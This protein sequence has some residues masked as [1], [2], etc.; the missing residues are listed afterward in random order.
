MLR[1]AIPVA[2]PT[3]P[4]AGATDLA[5]LHPA[6]RF[7]PA[8]N[9]E[10]SYRRRITFAQTDIDFELGSEVVDQ[11][12]NPV[13]GMTIRPEAFHDVDWLKTPHVCPVLGA[14]EVWERV[15]TTDEMHNFHIHQSKFRLA[16]GKL[17]KAIPAGLAP[18]VATGD[19]CTANPGKVAF[20]DPQGIVGRAVIETGGAMRQDSAV[21]WHD[22]IPVPPRGANGQPGRV[23][24]SIPFKAPE[25]V[26]RLVFHCHILEHEDGGM[27]APV[28]VFGPATIAQQQY[29]ERIPSMGTMHHGD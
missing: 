13:D 24:V 27:M 8:A 7:L 9:G 18:I 21:M 12:G 2:P 6:C 17:D 16:D 5:V 11:T 15:N 14:E 29:S 1:A 26:G 22:T 3:A 10:T 28:E 19:N 4:G 25:Q 20:C 23:F